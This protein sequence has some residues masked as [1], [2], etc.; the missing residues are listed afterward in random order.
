M[1]SHATAQR[2]TLKLVN[3]LL[4]LFRCAVAPLRG[5][6]AYIAVI[7]DPEAPGLVDPLLRVVDADAWATGDAAWRDSF[8]ILEPKF[9]AEQIRGVELS[10]DAHRDAELAWTVG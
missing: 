8:E 9:I 1:I 4:C 5:K 2:K 10:I 3:V 7:A 6:S